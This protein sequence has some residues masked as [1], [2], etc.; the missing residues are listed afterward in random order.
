MPLS[1]L[2]WTTFWQARG[3]LTGDLDPETE[4][5][6]HFIDEETEVQQASTICQGTHSWK[7]V[8]NKKAG[9]LIILCNFCGTHWRGQ[10]VL[11]ET[12]QSTSHS[13]LP[14][15]PGPFHPHHHPVSWKNSASGAALLVALS[16]S[17]A[18]ISPAF[19]L[20]PKGHCSIRSMD[21]P[22]PLNVTF[23]DPSLQVSPLSG[24]APCRML[25]YS[26]RLMKLK[27]GS[28]QAA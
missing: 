17:S 7:Q 13:T 5:Y 1:F 10:F 11:L 26:C 25:S 12:S 20:Y 9:F 3:A 18:D 22:C 16:P 19:S 2:Q 23:S 14:S 21:R 8:W 6:S 27:P 15:H 24:A 4:L 28:G